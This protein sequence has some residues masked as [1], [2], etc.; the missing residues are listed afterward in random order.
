MEKGYS[1]DYAPETLLFV[2]GLM[3][4]KQVNWQPSNSIMQNKICL[5]LNCKLFIIY[6]RRDTRQD[7]PKKVTTLHCLFLLFYRIG[8]KLMTKC[9]KTKL[10][11]KI[12]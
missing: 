5:K 7:P 2:I 6:T 10:L 1:V 8:E 11:D 4:G 3:K 9:L 12:T